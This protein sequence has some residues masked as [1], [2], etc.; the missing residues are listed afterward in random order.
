[1][2]GPALEIFSRYSKVEKADGSQVTLS[3]YLNHVWAAVARE[4][5][6]MIFQ[7]ADAS[8]F[9]EDSRLTAL[10]LWTL[11]TSSN[12]GGEEKQM[13]TEDNLDET[14]DQT[15]KKVKL[16]GFYLE[17][18]AARKLA[19][20]LGAHLEDLGKRGGIV[21]VE[22]D[23][24]RLLS[25]EERFKYLFGKEDVAEQGPRK[26]KAKVADLLDQME[27]RAEAGQ[28]LA[29]NESGDVKLGQTTLD[30]VHQS[31]LLFWESRSEALRRFLVDDGAGKDERFWRL[32]QALSALYPS[33]TDE[34]RWVDGVLA[35]KK[36]LGF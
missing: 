5:F 9:E 3:E 24:A 8:G 22:G 31:M 19:Q 15:S 7:G 26:K 11:H 4:A 17:Y 14:E 23:K 6:T 27:G 13:E 10:W 32:A 1:C 16:T 36:G 30:R 25:V 21:E 34:K 2:L 35:R 28:V 20:G 12:G 33:G 29:T 18:D